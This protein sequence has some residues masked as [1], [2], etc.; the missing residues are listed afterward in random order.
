MG[1][2]IGAIEAQNRD[3]QIETNNQKILLT[4][5]AKFMVIHLVTSSIVCITF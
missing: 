2:D 1:R 3:L 5:L 4:E